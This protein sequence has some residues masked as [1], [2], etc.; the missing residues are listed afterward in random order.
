MSASRE[1]A[2]GAALPVLSAALVILA[3][4]GCSDR[5]SATEERAEAP[6]TTAEAGEDPLTNGPA[7]D[8]ADV[9][10]PEAIVAAV[11]DVISGPPDEE[12]DWDRF[13]SLFGPD[14]RIIAA[15]SPEGE[16]EPGRADVEEYI[17]GA[18]EYFLR[19]GFWER[20]LWGRTDRFG[21][22]AQVYSAFE[23][24]VGSEESAPLARGIN[25]L[26]LLRHDDRW[27]IVGVVYDFERPDE[28]LPDEPLPGGVPGG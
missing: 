1:C 23:T 10:S 19:E 16:G 18:G 20:E 15:S 8:P 2:R 5:E 17:E 6:E 21:N 12:R 25:S 22:I 11:Y 4:L 24:R 26:Q 27:W 9:D 14:A 7:A 28:P 3:A 13:R